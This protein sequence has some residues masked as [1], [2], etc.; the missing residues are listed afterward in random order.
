MPLDPALN[1]M[2]FKRVLS[3]AKM[4]FPEPR[5]VDL[6]SGDGR[7]VVQAAL[8]GYHATGVEI[9]PYLVF[10]S[11]RK[12]A[13]AGAHNARFVWGNIWTYDLSATD[14]VYFF[15]RPGGGVMS[16]F[17]S[18][19]ESPGSRVAYAVSSHFDVPGWERALLQNSNGIRLY[20]VRKMSQQ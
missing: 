19:V 13:A 14:V 20:D 17:R 7:V 10:L 8:Q 16:R 1:D 15:G 18:R 3:R 11:R 9:N 4:E 2:L 5:M 12:A 6:G